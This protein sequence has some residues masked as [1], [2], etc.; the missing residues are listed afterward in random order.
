MIANMRP[1]VLVLGIVGLVAAGVGAQGLPDW[2]RTG[3]GSYA[4]LAGSDVVRV[5]FFNQ[6]GTAAAVSFY[7]LGQRGPVAKGLLTGPEPV[8]GV[9]RYITEHASEWI[10]VSGI[11]DPA[12]DTKKTVTHTLCCP[13]QMGFFSPPPL[14]RV[15][16]LPG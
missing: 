5:R 4:R 1:T 12:G 14:R 10:A 15:R 16:L 13:K 3:V 11:V 9:R 6:A 2:V 7:T 8:Q